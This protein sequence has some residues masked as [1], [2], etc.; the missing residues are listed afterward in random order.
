MLFICLVFH[1]LMFAFPLVVIF[2][3]V[4]SPPFSIPLW[5][6]HLKFP[7]VFCCKLFLSIFLHFFPLLF[8][9]TIFAQEKKKSYFDQKFFLPLHFF[10]LSEIVFNSL[11]IRNS[12]FQVLG[13]V[14]G[15]I[16]FSFWANKVILF[17]SFDLFQCLIFI[18][19]CEFI[20]EYSLCI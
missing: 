8:R 12:D 13:Q 20:R 5:I 17:L 9:S 18:L 2:Q 14:C 10:F 4:C 15:S 7:L 19:L 11:K 16:F 6:F 1:V 3:F